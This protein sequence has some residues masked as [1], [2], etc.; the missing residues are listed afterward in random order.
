MKLD[1]LKYLVVGAGFFGSVIAER[2]ANDMKQHVMLI[3]KRRHFGGNSHSS[4]D[5]S[6]G[7][8]YHTYGSHIFHTKNEKVWNYVNQF[9]TFNN[10]RHKVLTRH[11][12]STYI[13]P[14]NL[15]TINKLYHVD[16]S[17]D[18]AEELIKKEVEKE[19]IVSP[20]NFEEKA[21]SLIGS[22]LYNAFIKGY[23]I[24]QWEVDTQK[25]PASIITRLP[26]RYN[27][28]YDYF[29]DPYQGIPFHGYTALFEK[30]LSNKSLV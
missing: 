3:D 18:E 15:S 11:K 29:D 9:A 30:I 17:P 14:I 6:T 24:K 8:E 25:L 19:G 7:I 16:L 12:N 5:S 10:Y 4:V 20:G 28:Q 23:T 27:H 26:V 21:R 2:I 22:K 13:M 1:K